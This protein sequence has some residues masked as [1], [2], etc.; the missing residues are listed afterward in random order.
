[1]G[2]IP[3]QTITHMILLLPH[4]PAEA[5]IKF[6]TLVMPFYVMSNLQKLRIALKMKP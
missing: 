1:M 2:A 6:R 3:T 5:F 4:C